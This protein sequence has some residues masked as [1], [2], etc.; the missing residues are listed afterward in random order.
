LNCQRELLPEINFILELMNQ[1]IETGLLLSEIIKSNK[2]QEY[3]RSFIKF[4]IS[5]IT[6]E[7]NFKSS[8]IKQLVWLA[9]P[10]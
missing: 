6:Q 5:K 3:I 4:I 8:L 7:G 10:Q 1:G 9:T 2:D